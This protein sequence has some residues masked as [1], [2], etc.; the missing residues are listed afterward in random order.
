MSVY[1]QYPEES[2]F[3]VAEIE[4]LDDI[5]ARLRAA[6]LSLV[7]EDGETKDG[8][9]NQSLKLGGLEASPQQGIELLS[10]MP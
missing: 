9:V 3:M 7:F 5:G 1:M 2:A 10:H 8:E 4:K 6:H